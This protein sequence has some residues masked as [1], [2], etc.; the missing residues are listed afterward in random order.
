VSDSPPLSS[1]RVPLP[2]RFQI[3]LTLVLVAAVAVVG[4]IAVVRKG[5]TGSAVSAATTR[6]DFM[7]LASAQG[8]PAPDLSLPDQSGQTVSLS[9]LEQQ[10]KVIVLEFMDSHCTDICPIVS[11][12]F[13][14]AHQQLGPDAARVAFVGVNVNPFHIAQSDVAGFTDEQ[15]LNALPEWHFL[16]GPVP[17]LQDAWKK[18]GVAVQAPNPNVDIVHSDS[19]YFIDPTG[20]QRWIAI[21]TEDHTADG[22]AY[23]PAAQVRQW[24][25]DI[26]SVV[27]QMLH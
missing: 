18:Y 4:T 19:L 26:A 20:H 6:D 11:H 10:G 17:Q 22:T 16:T 21:P 5:S 1:R 25:V 15:G 24:G 23:L 12:E 8:A 3:A 14:V 2:S 7:G 27:R 9:G 13:V